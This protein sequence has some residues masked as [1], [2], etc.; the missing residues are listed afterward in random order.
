MSDNENQQ[1]QDGSSGRA[2]AD[3][4]PPVAPP[5]PPPSFSPAPQYYPYPPASAVQEPFDA[6]P[7]DGLYPGASITLAIAVDQEKRGLRPP[8]RAQLWGLGDVGITFIGWLG[9]SLAAG[10]LV[11]IFTQADGV[12]AT[13]KGALTVLAVMTPWIA[14]AGWP[15]LVTKL[16]GNGP[17]IDLGLRWSWRDI[18]WGVVYGIAALVTA[19]AL[20]AAT[21]ALFG[22]FSSAAGDLG[23]EL[24]KTNILVV[25]LFALSV[26]VG[27]PIVE[28]IC[29]RGLTFTSLAKRGLAPWLTVV[30][31][32][33]IFAAFHLEPIRLVLLFGIGLVLGIGRLHTGSTT[34]TIVAHMINNMPGAISLFMLALK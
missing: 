14:M 7:R 2:P 23:E 9:V 3:S 1:G 6:V 28:E 5:P 19:V 32:A 29:F 8:L 17:L 16:K 27:A 4:V 34:T 30:L 33:L 22:N 15:I 13:V 10:I 24:S 18:G 31:S 25:S 11:A 20:G 26:G 21:S 12:S